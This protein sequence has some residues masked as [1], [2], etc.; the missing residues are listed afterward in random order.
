[1]ISHRGLLV[2][3]GNLTNVN[4]FVY[5]L[6]F[7]STTQEIGSEYFP[8]ANGVVVESPFFGSKINAINSF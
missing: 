8:A 1:M 3:S 6:P 2:I 7:N 4:N 5:S